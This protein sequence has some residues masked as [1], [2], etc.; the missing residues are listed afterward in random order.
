MDTPFTSG[1]R[2]H[3]PW[4]KPG[5]GIIAGHVTAVEP[6]RFKVT[7]DREPRQARQR[8]W[9]PNDAAGRFRTQDQ[10]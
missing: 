7:W 9:Y 5:G 8:H 10:K 1:Q 6:H 3:L 4:E 2:L